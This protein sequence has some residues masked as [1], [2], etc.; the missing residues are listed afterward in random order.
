VTVEFFLGTRIHT[1][2]GPANQL[3]SR[4]GL[5]DALE[6]RMSETEWKSARRLCLI[7]RTFGLPFV[8][9][10]RALDGISFLASRKVKR[11][12][13]LAKRSAAYSTPLRSDA[14][15]WRDAR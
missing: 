4:D 3:Q 1:C 6:I 9:N 14:L 2:G 8:S 15:C 10:T 5:R 7:S 12:A 13:G 11:S